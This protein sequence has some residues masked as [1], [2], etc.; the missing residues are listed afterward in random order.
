MRATGNLVSE[1]GILPWDRKANEE[2]VARF[3]PSYALYEQR[4]GAPSSVNLAR[5]TRYET[6]AVVRVLKAW[7][8]QYA[9]HVMAGDGTSQVRERARP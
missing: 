8:E 9:V 6:G 7:P 2:F 1:F 4:V 3:A 5:G